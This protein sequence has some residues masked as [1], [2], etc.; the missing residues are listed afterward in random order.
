MRTKAIC[1]LCDLPD[2][3]FFTE[4][5]S[6]LGHVLQNAERLLAGAHI[7]AERDHAEGARILRGFGEE[8]AAK[9]LILLDAV[10][11][12]R[13]NRQLMRRQLW[14]FYDHLAK[15]IYATCCNYQPATFGELA[16]WLERD[17]QKFYLDGPKD[18]DWIFNNAI[19]SWREQRIYVDY[20]E[21]D[22]GHEWIVPI[23]TPLIGIASGVLRV[24]GALHAVGCATPESL[25]LIAR[26]WRPI[27]MTEDF[28]RDRLKEA[29]NQMLREMEAAGLLHEQ[30]GATYRNIV[31]EWFFPLCS[32][33]L[34]LNGVDRERLKELQGRSYPDW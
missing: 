18:D 6:G 23:P 17:C 7:L 24:V 9:Y 13:S 16:K 25:A 5:A 15:G 32:L 21:T 30:P 4:I 31:D 26:S 12:P 19:L 22:L 14:R 10:R 11:C 28:T 33:P 29:N 8:E 3:E 20:V 1:D 34:K 2:A 27:Q